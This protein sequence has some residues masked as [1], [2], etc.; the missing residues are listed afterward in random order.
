[1]A[2][3]H[4]GASTLTRSSRLENSQGHGPDSGLASTRTP[5]HTGEGE[6]KWVTRHPT[7]TDGVVQAAEWADRWIQLLPQS[8]ECEILDY[9]DLQHPLDGQGLL[10]DIVA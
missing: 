4:P 9:S 2:S 5:L 7:A 6:S 1:M 10:G 8:E 3:S